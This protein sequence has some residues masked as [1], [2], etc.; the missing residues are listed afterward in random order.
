MGLL[1][2]N[3]WPCLELYLPALIAFSC[4]KVSEKNFPK[5]PAEIRRQRDKRPRL[6]SV[7]LDVACWLTFVWIRS[8]TPRHRSAAMFPSWI[9]WAYLT[10]S[11][12]SL[13]GFQITLATALAMPSK[14]LN[15]D[16]NRV[17][18]TSQLARHS[19]FFIFSWA[20]KREGNPYYKNSHS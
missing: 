13:C 12:V 8:G 3:W 20:L 6:Y 5:V 1:M 14:T 4:S 11:F 16:C 10:A 17:L 2:A 15:H 9:P 7:E 19:F 18:G